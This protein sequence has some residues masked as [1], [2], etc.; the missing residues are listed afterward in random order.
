M[1]VVNVR[2]VVWGLAAAFGLFIYLPSPANQPL[3]KEIKLPPLRIQVGTKAPDFA[4]PGTEGKTVRLSDFSGR[5]VLI[6]FYRG[7]W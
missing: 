1:R 5:K 6:D 7:Y 3:G 4:L 2:L